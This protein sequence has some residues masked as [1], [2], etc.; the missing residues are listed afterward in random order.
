M[1][2]GIANK[3][4]LITGASQGIGLAT[5]KALAAEGV[6]VVMNARNETVLEQAVAA[7]REAGG[8]AF[9]IAGDVSQA[10]AINSIVETC[11]SLAAEPDIVV[12]N[13]G[14]PPAGAAETVTEAQCAQAYQLTLMSAV[15][16][17]KATL[18]AM[19]AQQWG[20]IINITSLSVKQP[21]ANLALSNTF[22][23]G[24]TGF[25]KTLATEVAAQGITINNVAPGYTAT[26]R[27]N[28]LFADSSAKDALVNTLPA[29]RLATPEEVAAAVLFFA[30]QQAAYITGQ[31]LTIDGGAVRSLF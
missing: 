14:G 17:A 28:E 27:L 3:T 21:V 18:P 13:A 15:R 20:R 19:Q 25:A 9:A 7:I 30:S 29:K 4:A 16:L 6:T 26:E 24:L 10:D 2:L 12:V 11:R 1:D 22:R 5:A 23:A 31:T 8:Q